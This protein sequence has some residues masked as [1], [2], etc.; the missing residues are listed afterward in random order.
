MTKQLFLF[1]FVA[2]CCTGCKSI[3]TIPPQHE[4]VLGEASDRNYRASVR[5]FGPA[6]IKVAAR[7]KASNKQTQGFGL[8]RFGKAKV[9]L[10]EQEKIT[11][12]NSSDKPVKVKTR[13]KEK[14]EGKKIQP[15]DK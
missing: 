10:S 5:N 8:G 12:R 14:V 9:Y 3:S 7:D 11:F 1:L 6:E 15:I 4:L 2:S 13:L